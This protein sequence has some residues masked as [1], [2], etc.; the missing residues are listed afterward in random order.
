MFLHYLK[1][2]WRN[3]VK[4]KTQSII[5]IVGLTFAVVFFTY[6]YHWYKFE[7][8]YDSFHPQAN[9]IYRIVSVNKNSGKQSDM[10][11]LPYIAIEKL[12]QAFP[13]IEK[14]AVIFPN[15]GSGF[16]FND[17]DLG[18]PKFEFVDERF[19]Q[20]FPPKVIAG[21]ITKSTFKN[22]NE[23]VLTESFARKYMG[24]PE[25]A[26]GE[27]LVSGYDESYIVKAVIAEYPAN[28]TFQKEGYLPDTNA[29]KFWS[30]ADE[31]VQW[32]DFNDAGAYFLLN[33][34]TDLKKFKE[35][36]TTFAI[37]NGYNDNLLFDMIPISK[38][39]HTLVNPFNKVSFDIK[40]IR[41]FIFSAL[42]LI[43]IA[44]FNYLNIYIN[45]IFTRNKEF[46]LRRVT[47]ASIK[48]IYRQL[49]VEIL[50]FIGIVFLLSFSLLELTIGFFEKTFDTI[51]FTDR[52]YTILLITVL[53]TGVFLYLTTFL[54]LHRF[55]HNTASRQNFN[56]NNAFS[57][58]HISLVLQLT[59]SLFFIMSAFVLYRQVHFMNHADW[60][61]NKD[62]LIQIEM[63]LADREPF[64]KAVRELPMVE[65]IISTGFFNI[66]QDVD[67]LGGAGVDGVE[68]EGKPMDYNPT[69]QTFG[70][71]VD[72]AKKIGLTLLNGDSFKME[73]LNGGWQSNKVIINETA[74]RTMEM[75]NPIGKKITIPALWFN[76][77]GRG[78]EE[79]EIIGVIRDFHTL[80][81]QNQIPPLLLKCQ[82][83]GD[84]GYFM[85]AR[86]TP[87]TETEAVKSINKL[88]Q[89]YKPDE[90]GAQIAKSMDSV[91]NELSKKEQ[92]VTNLFFTVAL[93]C[94][95]IAIFGIYSVSQRE[96]QRRRKEIAIRKTAGAKTTDVMALFFKEYFTIT[97]IACLVALPL[98]WFFMHKW[99]HAF[100]YRISISWWMFT[101][102]ILLVFTIV[103]LTIFSQV[104]KASSENPVEVVKSE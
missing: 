89:Q 34:K 28:S 77:Q 81:L 2:A 25:D 53:I 19:F 55:I 69:F 95:I 7:T 24:T 84:M 4:Y 32:R 80:S 20:M 23:I 72:F 47:G 56:G 16:K 99:L 31:I 36:L 104:R 33:E 70:A 88:A 46:N 92:D 35:K 27:T 17:K 75:Q 103:L 10:G 54:F 14:T 15:Y 6:G 38:I 8:T 58:N 79:F 9:R 82:N 94:I 85:Y 73:D 91:L 41:T 60:G 67:N 62:H 22:N 83:Q 68:W 93:L 98:A 78:K 64:M 101:L 44:F 40:Y 39:K 57:S 50:L 102:V 74:Q 29:R 97:A 11:T 76:E 100:A 45:S 37:D 13:E 42:L 18:Y 96:T 26:I 59:I 30:R 5:S 87:N 61:F 1:V 65:D 63:K 86:V 43:L 12:E 48:N 3:L 71:E 49:A 66:F 21:E 90:E 52:I 51:I